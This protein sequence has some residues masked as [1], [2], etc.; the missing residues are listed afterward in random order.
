MVFV[1]RV[2][3]VNV[4]LR[5]FGAKESDVVMQVS[6]QWIVVFS[7][8]SK[9]VSLNEHGSQAFDGAWGQVVLFHGSVSR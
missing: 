5:Q 4:E 2:A 1:H 6:Q 9:D 7:R 3:R 8:V